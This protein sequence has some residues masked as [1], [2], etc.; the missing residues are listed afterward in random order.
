[1]NKDHNLKLKLVINQKYLEMELDKGS[2]V[3]LVS[4]QTFAQLWPKTPLEASDIVLKTYS[5]ERMKTLG[6]ARVT[7]S[8]K[9][10]SW[11]TDLSVVRGDGPSLLG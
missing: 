3:T 10:Q 6:K 5:G 4:Q 11:D 8:Y 7:V 2:A 1:M 9:S